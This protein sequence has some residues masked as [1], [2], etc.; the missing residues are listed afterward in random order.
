[1]LLLSKWHIWGW[2]IMALSAD[3]VRLITLDQSG[4]Y[5]ILDCFGR[6]QSSFWF[7]P[8]LRRNCLRVPNWGSEVFTEVPAIYGSWALIFFLILLSLPNHYFILLGILLLSDFYP[9]ELQT[10]T[11]TLR[12]K[13]KE[14]WTQLSMLLF[15]LGLWPLWH[16]EI[17]KVSAGVLSNNSNSVH[18]SLGSLIPSYPAPQ[19]SPMTREMLQQ[20]VGP[21]PRALP[22]LHDSIPCSPCFSTLKDFFSFPSL[23][24]PLSSFLLTFVVPGR[25][26]VSLTIGVEIIDFQ[27]F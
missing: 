4:I 26:I 22:F 25:I 12:G 15:V 1:M 10:F 13:L 27:T 5:R 7:I 18:S 9:S 20:N 11:D 3:R 14:C 17:A 6:T 23:P 24:L 21:L 2:H 16:P 8:T 19:N